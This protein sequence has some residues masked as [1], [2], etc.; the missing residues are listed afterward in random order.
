LI[1]DNFKQEKNVGILH[2]S[3]H[4]KDFPKCFIFEDKENNS[5]LQHIEDATDC[6]ELLN[7]KE[8]EVETVVLRLVIRQLLPRKFLK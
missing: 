4:G 6:F 3:V 5:K 1:S 2:V 7:E 8:I